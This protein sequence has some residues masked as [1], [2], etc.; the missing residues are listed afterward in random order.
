[1]K[2]VGDIKKSYEVAVNIAQID[3]YEALAQAIIVQ[4]AE[5]YRVCLRVLAKR[6]HSRCVTE[7]Y[8]SR[9]ADIEWF[10]RSRWFEALSTADGEL[11]LERLRKEYE[12]EIS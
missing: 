2:P 3:P 9:K 6:K 8:L 5:D 7:R 10:F 12:D 1:M 11:I 4:A